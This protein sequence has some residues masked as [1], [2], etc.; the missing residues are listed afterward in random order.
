MMNHAR[1]AKIPEANI[2]VIKDV[3]DKIAKVVPEGKIRRLTEKEFDL[4][5][6]VSDEPHKKILSELEAMIK[7]S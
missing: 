2:Q 3:F 5:R 1:E 7:K 4:K 6:S